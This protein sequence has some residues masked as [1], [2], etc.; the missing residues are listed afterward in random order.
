MRP[1]PHKASIRNQFT[2]STGMRGLF[3][4]IKKRIMNINQPNKN[5]KVALGICIAMVIVTAGCSLVEY[6]KNLSIDEAT[7]LALS[8]AR[9]DNENVIVSSAEL[10]DED[11]R[12]MYEIEFVSYGDLYRVY[13]YDMDAKTGELVY[14]CCAIEE[15]QYPLDERLFGEWDVTEN[16]TVMS[17]VGEDEILGYTFNGDNTGCLT[18]IVDGEETEMEYTWTA[19]YP[20]ITFY[21]DGYSIPRAIYE[22]D[23]DVALIM[24]QGTRALRRQ[25]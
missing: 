1:L 3:N 10:V 16:S 15:P 14:A 18:V 2:I 23:G 12:Q 13:Q 8:A 20:Y 6:S 9:V 5:S 24:S 4:M 7:A 21:I 22:V 25:S 17:F 11:G 19:S